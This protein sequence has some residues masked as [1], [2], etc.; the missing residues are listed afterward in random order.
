MKA[1][2]LGAHAAVIALAVLTSAAQGQTY[3]QK[4]IRFVL[5]FPPGG[6][7]DT[8]G[9]VVGQKLGETMPRRAAAALLI[10]QVRRPSSSPLTCDRRSRN[11]GPW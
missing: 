2:K 8:L 10:S 3:P 6:G 1:I 4:P 11:G 5:P 9:R 7:T